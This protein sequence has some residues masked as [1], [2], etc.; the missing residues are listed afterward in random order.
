MTT[1]SNNK[2]DVISDTLFAQCH[3][4]MHVHLVLLQASL[5]M[6]VLCMLCTN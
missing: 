1:I 5:Y 2:Y 6:I 3:I 4:I